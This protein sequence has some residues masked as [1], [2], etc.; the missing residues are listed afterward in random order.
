MGAAGKRKKI[1]A[2]TSTGLFPSIRLQPPPPPPLPRQH[3]FPLSALNPSQGPSLTLPHCTSLKGGASWSPPHN[4]SCP[5]AEG[6]KP[7]TREEGR[8]LG[9]RE[10]L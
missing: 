10:M 6:R 3:S 1:L 2:L 9:S 4:W 5:E 8:G 7:S